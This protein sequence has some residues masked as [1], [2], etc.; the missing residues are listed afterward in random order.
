MSV[1]D[2]QLMLGHKS[3]STTQKYLGKTPAT[4][5]QPTV[6]RAFGD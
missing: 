4:K 3:L 6:D 5:L 1:R 2:I